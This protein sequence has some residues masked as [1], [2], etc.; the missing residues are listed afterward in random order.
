MRASAPLQRGAS[1]LFYPAALPLSR[2]PLA[3][4]ARVICRHRRQIGS[5]WRKLTPG[6]QALL[7]LAYL[8]KGETYAELAAWFGIGTAY[9][10]AV[11]PCWPPGPLGCAGPWTRPG[12]QGTPT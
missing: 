6:Q 9:R 4:T 10:L 12:R 8:R 3:Y 2:Q 7:V 1:T 11:W 5:P